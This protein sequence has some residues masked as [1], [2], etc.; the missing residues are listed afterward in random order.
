MK[1]E[2]EKQFGKGVTPNLG[3]QRQRDGRRSNVLPISSED[4]TF[5][6]LRLIEWLKQKWIDVNIKYNER[7]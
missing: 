1:I 2:F 3:M 7:Y 4:N 6:A 5:L